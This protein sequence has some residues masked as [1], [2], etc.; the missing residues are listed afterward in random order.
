[1]KLLDQC[2]LAPS[3]LEGEGW[4][5]GFCFSAPLIPLEGREGGLRSGPLPLDGGGLG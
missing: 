4:G 3:P 5:G 1:M 2:L